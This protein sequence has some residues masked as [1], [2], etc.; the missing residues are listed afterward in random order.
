MVESHA[1]SAASAA[2]TSSRR[3]RRSGAPA[4]DA[5]RSKA[6]RAMALHYGNAERLARAENADNLFYPAKNGISAELRLAFLERRPAEL[7]VDRMRAVEESL[8]RAA[9]ERPDFW[10]V[11]GQIELRVLVA[12]AGQRLASE[13]ASL[14]GEF[15]DLKARVPARTMWDSV[16]AEAR[17]TIE[18]YAAVAAPAERRA[19]E[20]LLAALRAMAAG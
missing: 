20:A 3:R 8:A 14:I 7:A 11:V 18:P 1:A 9:R 15:G 10:S 5:D 13:S 12:V 19:A 17:F 2:S 4:S 6:L 16:Y